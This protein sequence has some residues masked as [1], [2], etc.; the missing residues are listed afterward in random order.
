MIR[1][2]SP[3]LEP[4]LLPANMSS[5]HKTDFEDEEHR[6]ETTNNPSDDPNEEFGGT[7][8]RNKMEKKLL[9]KLDLRMSI[10]IVIYILNYV[11]AL[12]L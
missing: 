9:R 1:S 12:F 4:L 10:L 3:S 6:V 5:I 11:R 8:E 7:E 2:R